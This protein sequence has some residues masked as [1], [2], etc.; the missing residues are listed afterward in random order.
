MIYVTA[1]ALQV[2]RLIDQLPTATGWNKM[3]EYLEQL[4]Q[5][6]QFLTAGEWLLGNLVAHV[7]EKSALDDTATLD[8]MLRRTKDTLEQ[9]QAHQQ[10][11][12][13]AIERLKGA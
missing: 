7:D 3:L 13:D 5:A 1:H 10:E 6:D 11:A 12:L 8:R 2:K 4:A 9:W